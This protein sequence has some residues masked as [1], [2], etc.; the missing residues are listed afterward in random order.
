MPIIVNVFGMV[1]HSLRNGDNAWARPRATA[2]VKNLSF[3]FF[4]KTGSSGAGL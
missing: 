4:V 2:Y 1:S 3:L